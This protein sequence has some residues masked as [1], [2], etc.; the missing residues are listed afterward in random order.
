[1]KSAR[2]WGSSAV[3]GGQIVSREHVLQEGDVIELSM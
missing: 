3:F 2:I 1:M